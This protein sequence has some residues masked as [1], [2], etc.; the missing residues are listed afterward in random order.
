MSKPNVD[1]LLATYNGADFLGEQLDS[2]LRQTYR[3]WQLLIRDDGSEDQT[4]NIIESYI[5]SRSRQ[6]YLF[7]DNHRA[8]GAVGNF[9]KLIKYSQAEYT[10]FCDQDD[11]WL[12]EKLELSLKRMQ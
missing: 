6:I 4:L 5:T 11:V 3:D 7:K 10:L 12:K 9:A 2:L 1:I 8:L